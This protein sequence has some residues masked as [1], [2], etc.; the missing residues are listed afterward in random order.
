MTGRVMRFAAA[1]ALPT[2]MWLAGCAELG[3][4][5]QEE[6]VPGSDAAVASA[7]MGRLSSDPMLGRTSFSVEVRHG[8]AT[9]RG[10]VD[11]NAERVRALQIVEDTDGVVDV[12]DAIRRR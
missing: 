10:V 2:A 4:Q 9:V 3:T 5:W 6:Q 8:V 12:K 11:Q 7:A 1:L